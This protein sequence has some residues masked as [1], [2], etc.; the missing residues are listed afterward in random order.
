MLQDRK[1]HTDEWIDETKAMCK[2]A[3]WHYVCYSPSE[4][5]E[6]YSVGKT[7]APFL[8]F[9]WIPS[10]YLLKLYL[11]RCSSVSINGVKECIGRSVYDLLNR[12]A[13]HLLHIFEGQIAV[14][15]CSL[16]THPC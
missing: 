6:R 9:A 5:A 15:L 16:R 10:E 14:K 11:R 8:S 3:A 13:T 1:I 7:E 12:D 4:N 2:A